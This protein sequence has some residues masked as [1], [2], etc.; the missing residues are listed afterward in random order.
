MQ[1]GLGNQMFQYATGRRLA[2]IFNTELKINPPKKP[3][4]LKAFNIQ[5]SFATPEETAMTK[6]VKYAA[7][8][9]SSFIPQVLELP[10]NIQLQ[11]YFENERYFADIADIIRKEFT[12]KNPLS[13]VAE[14]WRQRISS[15]EC[16][17]SMHFR[18]GDF[19]KFGH[20]PQFAIPP[21]E[22][23][24][25]ALKQLA[26]PKPTVF[27]FSDDLPW[28]KENLKLDLPT[29]FVEGCRDYE[30]LHLI[31]LCKHNINANSTFSW[32]GAWLNQNSDKKV[33]VPIPNTF[34]D[35]NRL[36]RGFAPTHYKYSSLDSE[37]WI[38]IPFDMNK[39]LNNLL[40]PDYRNFYTVANL[41]THDISNI[42]RARL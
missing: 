18:H 6:L 13:P 28:C 2:H 26:E 25:T 19:L 31:S 16:A 14:T 7:G 29:E 9:L 42:N 12:L 39:R 36:Y 34:F 27:V 20:L 8:A 5:E 22:Y 24:L 1:G 17:V 15:A 10:D 30:D 33:F 11:G 38:R 35:E 3:Y 32:W 21:L 4:G 23:Y 41:D 37:R 40:P